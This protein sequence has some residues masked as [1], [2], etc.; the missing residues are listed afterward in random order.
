MLG[1]AGN[2]IAGRLS[3]GEISPMVIVFLRW[4]VV[5]IFL[6]LLKPSTIIN[7]ISRFKGKFLWLFLM[8]GLGYT[9]FNSL[10]YIAAHQ[11]TAINLGIIQGVMP[12]MILVGS[13][14]FFK[15]NTN[16]IQVGGL[17]LT[18]LGVL[19][20]VSKGNLEVLLLLSLNYG[21]L[22]MFLSCFLYAGF[23]LGLK[24]KPSVDPFALMFFFS[25]TALISS[26]VL[27][28]LESHLNL[29]KWPSGLSDYIIILYIAFIPSLL[30][31]L[32]FIRGVGCIGYP[33]SAEVV[34]M[35]PPDNLLKQG[36]TH[37]PTV[38]DGRQSGTS[39]SPSILNASPESVVG[40]GLAFLQTG[41]LVTLDLNNCSL[42][43]EVPLTEW[44][45]RKKDWL[46]PT[47]ENQTPWQEIYRKN[48]GQLAD[49]GCLELATAYQRIVKHIPRDNH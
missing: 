37:L 28:F 24:Y 33:G 49:G 16:L 21:D 13:V 14:M 9:G 41:D 5:A 27:L 7:S 46:P 15:E 30:S 18:F 36:I 47:I 22:I 44:E 2:T 38:G 10:F 12:A 31:Q 6:I 43:A 20:L 11:T 39:E 40:G 34:N 32:L 4:S 23:T 3:T 26:F 19:I 29:V 8:G 42:N 1:W 17:L 48:V 35:Q 25:I 45:E